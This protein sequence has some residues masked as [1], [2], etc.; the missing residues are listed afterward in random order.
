[1]F[2]ILLIL[3]LLIQSGCTRIVNE[4]ATK[5]DVLL[6]GGGIMSATLGSILK[7]LDSGLDMEIYE[8]MPKT[9][10]ESSDGWNN[11]GT[12]HAAYCELNYTP[13]K[14]D[15]SIDT[16]KAVEI[17]EAFEIS[18]QFW[19]YLVENKLIN[20]PKDFIKSVPHMSFVMGKDNVDFLHKRYLAMV[21]NP[22]FKG[23]EYTED[24]QRIKEWAPLVMEGRK[25]DEVVAATRMKQGTDVDFGALTNYMIKAIEDKGG[26]LFLK[27][28]VTDIYRDKEGLWS[29]VIKDLSTKKTKVVRS[30]FVFIGAGGGALPLLQKTGIKEAEGLGGFPVGGEWLVTE[31]KEIIDRHEAKVYGLASVG[32]PPMSVPHLDSRYIGSKESLLFGP[33]ATFSTKFLV[34]GSWLDL[35]LS[36]S[37][38]NMWPMLKAGFD[39]LDLVKYLIE[40]VL[41][42]KEQKLKALKEY[43]P[44]AQLEDWQTLAAGQRVQVIKKDQQKGGVLQFGTEL[45]IS[46]DGTIAALLGASPGASVAPKVMLDVI[47]T[48]FKEKAQSPDWRHKIEQLAPSY[49]IELHKDEARL[50]RLREHTRTVLGL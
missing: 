27:H 3:L 16:K 34:H 4:N 2:N 11:A 33:F 35:P 46:Q 37:F 26:R 7:E 15:G 17:A 18:R 21:Q 1:M 32:S 48:S 8:R 9:A 13:K 50:N 44:D 38:S 49:N 30:K 25:G 39:N 5:V 45:V 47:Q 40:Q 28:E 20:N 10:L 43:F 14:A 22:L 41:L 19:A 12:G 42:S 24:P 6:I 31:K 36:V 29:V 23:M